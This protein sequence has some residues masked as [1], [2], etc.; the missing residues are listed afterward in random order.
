MF[1][2]LFIRFLFLK[3]LLS[4]GA[5]IIVGASVALPACNLCI[6]RCLYH[7]I[8]PTIGTTTRDEC[9]VG[10]S[11]A[12]PDIVNIQS[13]RQRRREMIIN[14]LITIGI[15]VLEMLLGKRDLFFG[16]SFPT[17][18]VPFAPQNSWSLVT[19]STSSRTTAVHQ[20]HISPLLL[21]FLSTPCLSSSVLFR[22]AMGVSFRP[23]FH[24]LE[25]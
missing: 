15:P 17:D 18:P 19:G 13:L 21:L 4:S 5:R 22:P 16:P 10:R 20:P 6:I 12:S 3:N 1:A 11:W 23:P 25:C 7:I 24:R 8:S 2:Y 14:L 9:V